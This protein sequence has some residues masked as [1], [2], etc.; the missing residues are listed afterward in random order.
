[1]NRTRLMA[2]TCLA[3]TLAAGAVLA[4]ASQA[5][6][7]AAP[8]AP[9]AAP[10]AELGEV[11]VTARKRQESILNVP[12]IE[13]AVTAQK[14]QRYQTKDL[15]DIATLVPGVKLGGSILS[16]GTQISV[17]GVGTT[18]FNP[19]VDQ[20]VSLNLD[21]LQLSQGLTYASGFFDM[22]QV[23]VL[24]GPQA[25]FYGKSSP[26]GVISIRTADPTD[27]VEVIA[28]AGYEFEAHEQQYQLIA[29]GPITDTLKVRLAGQYDAQD[30][31]Y[32]NIATSGILGGR[33]P[34]H[35]RLSPD[36]GY[37][38]RATLLW[39]PISQFDARLKINQVRDKSD[40]AGA[41]QYVL[42]PEGPGPVPGFGIP[43][44]NP[45][46]D[47]KQD[48]NE[49]QVAMDPS[50]YPGI[51][52]GGTPYLE[53]TQTFGTLEM[54]YRVRPDL[55][56]TSTTGYY[57]L[58]SSSLF[59]TS[60][61]GFAGPIFGVTNGFHRR[62]VT[63]EVRANSD[64]AG[65]LNFT[66]GGFLQRAQFSDLVTLIGNRDIGLPPV[67]AK[68]IQ[69]VDITTNSVF[70]QLRYKV[71]PKVEIALGARWTDEKRTDDATDLRTGVAVPVALANPEIHSKTTSPEL[72]ITYKPTDD[73]TVFAALKRGYKSGSFDTATPAL[74][75][76]DNAFGD[77]KV[78]G[79]EIG[80]KSRWLDR[81]MAF[82]IAAYDY[83]YTG[84]QVGAIVPVE[85]GTP[86]ITKTINAGSSRVYGIESDVV[87]RP[88]WFEGL[89]LNGALN[90]NY[91]R[92]KSLD[93]VP[94]YGGQTIALGCN[95]NFNTTVNRGLGGFTAQNQSGLPL[96]RAPRW[97]TN[98]GFD[99][100]TD[101]GNDLKLV[102]A[103]NTQ[104]SSKY[105]TGLGYVHYQKSAFK[106]DLSMTVQG[107]NDRW[108]FSLI[109][110]NLNNALTSG[111]CSNSNAAAGLLGGQ[112]TGTNTLGPA[113]I[114]EVGCWMDRGREVW[115]QV[116][117]KPFS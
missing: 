26:G 92:F 103:S 85:P 84:L 96:V 94:C 87:Y 45:A 105:L 13:T 99:Y 106:T 38:L 90:W 93:G 70:G 66:A 4:P 114:D 41:E 54:N 77:E 44:L 61:T 48:R 35:N 58:H 52:N 37:M 27:R 56:L 76:Q 21:G 7:Q 39:N 91:A 57:L 102:L 112:L 14:L 82:N 29:S 74:P 18:T 31:F 5:A 43:F 51:T 81:R 1:M 9:A 30:G 107:P 67:F 53:T 36:K 69:V 101:I 72:T 108:E 63:E 65:P 15:K 86:P 32:N 8:A 78:E 22:A 109:G 28:R 40:E 97:Q 25:L 110:K 80:L 47:C 24:K 98:F 68:G 111:N 2:A 33:A 117:Y 12:V 89:T 60:V 79:G 42:C 10:V 88:E 75:G 73:A 62:E 49:A 34:D 64:F 55:T 20:S 116:T 113:G 46:E 17:R 16:I 100:E 71:I 23:E 83:R 59:N 95:E 6:A 115:L 19:G 11:I 3:S 104:F 50:V